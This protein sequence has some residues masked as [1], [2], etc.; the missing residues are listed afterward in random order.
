MV[1]VVCVSLEYLCEY[2]VFVF[3]GELLEY[4]GIDWDNLLLFYVW[5]FQY[6]G[7]FQYLWLKWVWLVI[8]NVEVMVDVVLVGFGI[9]YLLIWLCSE[10]LLCGELQVLFC[11]DGLFVVEFI[12]IYVLCLECEVSL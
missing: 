9:V 12:C 11:D 6:D 1:W 3:F 4:V 7:K 5:C 8:N 2:G 10:Y